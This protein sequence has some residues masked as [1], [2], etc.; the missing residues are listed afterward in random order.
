MTL[1][2]IA[3]LLAEDVAEAPELGELAISTTE[4]RALKA[5]AHSLNPVVTI[6]DNGLSETVLKEIN[7]SLNAHGL[8]KIR[9]VSD[10]R[11]Q[12]EGYLNEICHALN[13]AAVQHIGKLLVI[14]RPKPEVHIDKS[15][16]ATGRR[17]APRQLKR[18]FQNR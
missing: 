15:G 3:Q 5:E 13:A 12:R 18:N 8:I 9:V 17:K 7:H 10:D 11:E 16:K 14:W 1:D 2:R 4:R 6:A